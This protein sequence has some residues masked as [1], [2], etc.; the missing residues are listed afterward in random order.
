MDPS[1][2]Q[3]AKQTLAQNTTTFALLLMD[4]MLLARLPDRASAGRT[5]VQAP[6]KDG[7]VSSCPGGLLLRR[8]STPHSSRTKLSRLTHRPSL[9]LGL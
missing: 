4:K 3:H 7:A 9:L 2:I 6:A 5:T 8:T 1:G